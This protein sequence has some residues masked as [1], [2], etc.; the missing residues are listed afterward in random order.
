MRMQTMKGKKGILLAV[1]V[2]ALLGSTGA[3]AALTAAE[4][5]AATE[6]AIAATKD[7][8]THAKAGHKD[9]TEAAL[10]RARQA[11]KELTGDSIGRQTQKVNN[12]LKAAIKENKEGNNAK[13][14]ESI[15]SVEKQLVDIKGLIQ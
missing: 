15:N 11:S 5:R 9:E 8:L 12:D 3:M 10:K 7:A 6:K 2:A 14:V 1:A 4:G 13:V